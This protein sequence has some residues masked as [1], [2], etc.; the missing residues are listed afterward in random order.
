MKSLDER[1]RTAGRRNGAPPEPDTETLAIEALGFLAASPERLQ[2]FMATTGASVDDIRQSMSQPG[3]AA[4]I[5][6]YM[7][8]DD[9]LLIGFAASRGEGPDATAAL[10]RRHGREDLADG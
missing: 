8:S 4:G 5:L 6:A 3:F 7:A 2:T 10:L 9:E 1:A